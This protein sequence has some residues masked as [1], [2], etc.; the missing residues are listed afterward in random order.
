MPPWLRPHVRC[1][2]YDVLQ[3]LR[4]ED[5]RNRAALRLLLIRHG[6][7][8]AN[9]VAQSLVCGR[10]VQTPLTAK[11]EEQAKRLGLRLQREGVKID[12][13]VSSHAVRAHR[14]AEIAC[15]FHGFPAERIEIDSRVVEMSQGALEKQPRAQV[16][17]LGGPTRESI[18]RDGMFFR[19]PGHSPDGDRGE[20]QHDVEVRMKQFVD[21]L[22]LEGPHACTGQERTVVVFSHGI[23]IRSFLRGIMGADSRYVLHSQTE[24]TSITELVY[25]PIGGDFGGWT[26]VRIND[27]AH[28]ASSPEQRTTSTA[29][30]AQEQVR[31]LNDQDV[32]DR[33][34]LGA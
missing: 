22:L 15:S 20:S 4:Q 32:K 16:Y 26:V 21:E 30:R 28:L 6:E 11:G 2:A 23:A 5:T 18:T 24:N 34:H 13:A 12:Q 3:R 14:T 31:R 25:K 8:M 33:Q 7:S 17:R 9:T 27:A 29:A 19:P 1:V 10:D